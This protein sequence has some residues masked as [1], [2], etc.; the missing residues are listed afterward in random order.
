[1]KRKVIKQGNGTLTITLPKQWTKKIGLKGGDEIEIKEKDYALLVSKELSTEEKVANIRMTSDSKRYIRS[2]IGRLYRHGYATINL[3]FDNP[4]LI[5]SIKSA[6]DNLI[7]ADIIDFDKN[8]CVVKIF[9][10]EEQAVNFDKNLVKMLHTFKYMLRL[11]KEDIGNNKFK[12]EETLNE[13]RNNNWKLKD[14]ILRNAFLQSIPYEEFSILNTILF[15][16][17]K[18]GTNLLGF[19]R[20]YLEGSK[21]KLNTK[22]LKPVFDKIDNFIEWFTKHISKKEAIP[23]VDESRFRKEMRDYHIYLYNKLH[24]DKTIDHP[25][26]TMVYFTVELLDSTVS[27]LSIYKMKYKERLF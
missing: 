10:I 15:A 21:K 3:T 8:R 20:M 27:F 18:I 25:F 13:L 9:P 4:N 23:P 2:H 24:Q 6:T 11:I 7:G 1:M 17:E 5:K 19:Y 12:R 26:L 22:K 16:Y 14:Y